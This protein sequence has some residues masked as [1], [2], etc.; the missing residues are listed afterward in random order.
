MNLIC[1]KTRIM[2]YLVIIS[3]CTIVLSDLLFSEAMIILIPCLWL[4]YFIRR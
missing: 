4:T 2:Q 3:L 1:I